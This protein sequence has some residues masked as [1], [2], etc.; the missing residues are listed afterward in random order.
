MSGD[1]FKAKA[2]LG[3]KIQSSGL[4]LLGFLSFGLL[5]YLIMFYLLAEIEDSNYDLTN[6]ADITAIMQSDIAIYF[7]LLLLLIFALAIAF[8]VYLAMFISYLK[9]LEKT[10]R[11]TSSRYLRTAFWL[12]IAGIGLAII[13]LFFLR[14]DVNRVVYFLVFSSSGFSVFIVRNYVKWIRDFPSQNARDTNLEKMRFLLQLR[15][16]LLF[17]LILLSGLAF[18]FVVVGVI[19]WVILFSVGIGTAFCWWQI[20]KEIKNAFH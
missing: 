14:L 2:T 6:D 18:I 19:G 9:Q 1:T 3:K 15:Q 10:S 8:F 11:M 4:I 20:G 17:I 7:Y 16:I 13:V 5:I 12:D